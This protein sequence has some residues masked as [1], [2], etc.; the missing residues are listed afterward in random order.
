MKL[1]QLRSAVRDAVQD[2]FGLPEPPEDATSLPTLPGFD[3]LLIARLL[4]ELE[5][6][7][8]TDL[9]PQYLVPEVFATPMALAAAFEQHFLMNSR[10][11]G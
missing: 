9:D 6:R 10:R 1:E 4:E 8:G 3:S 11:S 5:S 7:L 2:V